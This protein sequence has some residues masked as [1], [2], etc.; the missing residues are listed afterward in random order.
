VNS[1]RVLAMQGGFSYQASELNR[2]TQAQRQP[3]SS[4]KPFVYAAALDTGFTPA[5]II[6]DAPIEIDTPDGIWRPENASHRY[7]GPAPMRTGIEQSRNLMTIRLAQEVTM[8]VVA[9]YAERF[10]VYD[11]MNHFLANA[12]GSQETTIYRMVAAYSMLANGGERVEPTLV[13]RVQDRWGRTVYRHDQRVC[14]D[15]Q[16]PRLAAGQAPRISSHREQVI[17]AITAYQLTSMLEGVVQRGTA[18]GINLPVPIAGKTGT[19][20]DSKDVWFI[21]YSSSIAAGCYIGF[22]QPRSLGSGAS[23]GGMCGPVFQSFMEQA[24]KRYG[25]TNFRV[26]PGG[27]FLKVDR[28][29]GMRLPDDASGDYVVSEYFRDGA[30]PAFGI[31]F[32]GGFAIGSNLL[33]F[34]QGQS[35]PSEGLAV[36]TA[37]GERRVIPKQATFGT[38]SSGGLY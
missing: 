11:R 22:D 29:S 32:D 33:L 14:D 1:G 25:G 27:F 19:T 18:R 31:Y 37:T 17:N 21:G 6:I 2:A 38:I 7:Y 12:L 8:P 28:F 23:G 13:D 20:N 24:I 16:S 9:G 4:F 34:E 26:P 3:G 36:T 30:E 5:S 10:G 35:D 15:C